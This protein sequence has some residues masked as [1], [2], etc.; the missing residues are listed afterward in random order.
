MPSRRKGGRVRWGSGRRDNAADRGV[1]FPWSHRASSA[2]VRV[3]ARKG[4]SSR[5]RRRAFAHQSTP[6]SSWTNSYVCST[7]GNHEFNYGLDFMD[8]V[9]AGANFPIVCAN[10]IRGT[11]LASNPRDDKLYLKPYIIVEKTIKDGPH[12]RRSGCANNTRSR[13]S[14]R[15]TPIW[16]RSCEIT[17]MRMPFFACSTNDLTATYFPA[18]RATPKIVSRSG[19]PRCKR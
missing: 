17:Q 11:T 8:K 12:S 7:L 16:N 19:A 18:R 5:G 13:L 3:A 2:P 15:F 14:L 10:L 9:K 6:P 4:H 1:P